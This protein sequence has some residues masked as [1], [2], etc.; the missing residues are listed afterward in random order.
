MPRWRYSPPSLLFSVCWLTQFLD[1]R[2]LTN[3]LVQSS[4]TAIVA[5]GMTFVLLTA[6]VDLSVGAIMFLSAAIAGKL[7]LAEWPLSVALVVILVIGLVF[8]AVNA[9]FI[10]RFRIMAFIVTLATLYLGRGLALWITQTRAMNLPESFLLLGT[11]RVAGVPAPILVLALVL[12]AA[13]FVLTRTPFG[14]Q[15][16]AVGSNVEMARKAGL[17]TRAILASVYL[18]SGFC[19]ALGGIVALSQL[20][21][22]SPTFGNQKE[23][24][25]SR[26]QCWAGPACS[27]AGPGLSGHDSWRCAHSNGRERFGHSERGSL[28]LPARHERHYLF[29]G[30]SR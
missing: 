24:P 30:V 1:T 14:R 15:I 27:G 17:N 11:T 25:P 26:R 21:A 13:H 7:A 18:I 22:V 4:S 10:T 5:I 29:G 12:A 19:A 2:N 6:G 3:I 28:H 20:G 16:Y 9:L 8:G 23:S